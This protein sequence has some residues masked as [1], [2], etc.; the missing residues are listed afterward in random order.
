MENKG[1]SASEQN[2]ETDDQLVVVN[3]DKLKMLVSLQTAVTI[4]ATQALHG[5]RARE[6]RSMASLWSMPQRAAVTLRAADDVC[7]F[8]ADVRGSGT[9]DRCDR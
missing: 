7:D 5:T 6:I 1:H 8:T 2:S 3:A 4:L 9:R